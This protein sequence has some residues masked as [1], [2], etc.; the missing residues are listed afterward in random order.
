MSNTV[1]NL[2][3]DERNALVPEELSPATSVPVSSND[4][5]FSTTG[6][7]RDGARPSGGKRNV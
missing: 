5:G 2:R 7:E 6:D 1:E 4:P 3:Y